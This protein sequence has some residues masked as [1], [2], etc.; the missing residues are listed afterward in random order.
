[1]SSKH[2]V[3]HKGKY[4]MQNMCILRS[5]EWRMEPWSYTLL[6]APCADGALETLK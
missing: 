5:S 4:S 6:T 1:M 3:A 2:L